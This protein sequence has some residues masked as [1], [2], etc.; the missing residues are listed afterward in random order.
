MAAGA[1]LARLQTQLSGGRT[2]LTMVMLARMPR[3]ALMCMSLSLSLSLQ[4][5]THRT[6]VAESVEIQA[7]SAFDPDIVAKFAPFGS[8]RTVP[9]RRYNIVIARS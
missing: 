6:V 2:S 1:G 9:P 5:C 8:A 4:L 7:A 3:S